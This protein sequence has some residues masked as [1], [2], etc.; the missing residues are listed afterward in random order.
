VEEGEREKEL[1]PVLHFGGLI[2]QDVEQWVV[3]EGGELRSK[4]RL[5]LL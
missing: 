4:L 5:K 2:L 1:V 3:A